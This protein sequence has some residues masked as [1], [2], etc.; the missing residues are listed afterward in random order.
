MIKK[1]NNDNGSHIGMALGISFGLM[2]GVTFSIVLGQARLLGV[3][4][5]VGMCVGMLAGLLID[6]KRAAKS[7]RE[8]PEP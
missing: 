6:S 8:D 7:N 3:G 1:T 5:G 4:A 2:A